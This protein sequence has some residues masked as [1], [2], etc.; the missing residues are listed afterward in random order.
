MAHTFL[1]SIPSPRELTARL[2]CCEPQLVVLRD[3]YVLRAKAGINGTKGAELQPYNV[4][5]A[6]C[7]H[8]CFCHKRQVLGM[9]FPDT[10][11]ASTY[12]HSKQPT[13]ATNMA[14]SNKQ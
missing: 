1:S 11:H 13:H 7:M 2:H 3:I 9:R 10:G 14:L 5:L 8:A 4:C 6:A 12:N